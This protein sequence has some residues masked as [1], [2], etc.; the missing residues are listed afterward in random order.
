MKAIERARAGRC[1]APSVLHLLEADLR[2]A[3]LV[4]PADV[5]PDVVTMNSCVEAVDARTGRPRR[6]TLVYPPDERNA[7]GRV[8]VLSAEGAALLGASVGETVRWPGAERSTAVVIRS[9]L[10][11]PEAAGDL[12]L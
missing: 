8:S 6:L 12:H 1:A 10:Y 7:P 9:L 2:T 3:D 4:S 11:Q 5:F